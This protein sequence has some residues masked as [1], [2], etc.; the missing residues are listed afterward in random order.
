MNNTHNL[1]NLNY[2]YGV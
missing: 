2:L 1:S